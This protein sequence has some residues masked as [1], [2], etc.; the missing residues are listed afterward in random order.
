MLSWTWCSR[1][2]ESS[3]S[4]F[5]RGHIV[6]VMMRSPARGYMF[7]N[8]KVHD[9]KHKSLTIHR[10]PLL[11]K[12]IPYCKRRSLT[13]L[14]YELFLYYRM[15]SFAIEGNPSL[16]RKSLTIEGTA[17]RIKTHNSWKSLTTEGSPLLIRKLFKNIP[18]YSLKTLSVL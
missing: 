8:R 13:P 11:W 12:G 15:K 5:D 7:N 4:M 18:H 16:I 10:N 6:L 2:H 1:L 9:Y 14:Q 3:I 17:L